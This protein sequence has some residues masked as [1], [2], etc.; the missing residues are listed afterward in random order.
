[1]IKFVESENAREFLNLLIDHQHEKLNYWRFRGHSE[2][3]YSLIPCVL[4][5][6]VVEEINIIVTDLNENIGADRY[7]LNSVYQYEIEQT[8]LKSFYSLCKQ[9]G[10]PIPRLSVDY[11]K[12]NKVK[13]WIADDYLEIA[14]LAQHYGLPT[15]LLDWT[16]DIL[17]AAFF[18]VAGVD[19]ADFISAKKSRYQLSTGEP[20]DDK[21]VIWG[22]NIVE[23]TRIKEEHKLDDLPFEVINC[24]YEYNK[25]IIAQQGALSQWKEDFSCDISLENQRK[26]LDEKFSEYFAGKGIAP[27]N[28]FI[29]YTL[30]HRQVANLS[31]LLTSLN[32][33][34]AK[35]FPGYEG[36]VK[37]MM[38]KHYGG[39]GLHRF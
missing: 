24:S 30:P 31:K 36:V 9:H 17:S 16:Y 26:P 37:S 22:I 23:L 27:K 18:A 38:N 7:N 28:I 4:R 14:A 33:S 6:G 20:K 34:E 11:L 39:G 32:Y 3:S 10:L 19:S 12:F 35:L 15:R 1:M 25:N 2:S 29:K 21:I 5:P 8:L 13:K